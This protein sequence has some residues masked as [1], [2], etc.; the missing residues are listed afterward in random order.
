MP[1]NKET[2][3]N[4]TIFAAFQPQIKRV[5]SS[6]ETKSIMTFFAEINK[7]ILTI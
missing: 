6:D 2:K 7:F 3:P 1:L 4:Q 5:K